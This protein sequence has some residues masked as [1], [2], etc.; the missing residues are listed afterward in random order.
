MKSYQ[1]PGRRRRGRG[2]S[3]S[4]RKQRGA[5]K[6]NNVVG[7]GL[8]GGAY[9][10]LSHQDMDRIH[11]TALDILENIGL[12]DP[13]ADLLALALEKGCWLNE[14]GRL[15]F[16]RALVEDVV[17]GACKEFTIYGRDPAFDIQL[18][19]SK[20]SYSVAG[21]AVTMFDAETKTYRPSTLL[22]LYDLARLVDRLDN[23]H[24]FC[25]PVIATDIT[26][27]YT[28]STNIAYAIL[29]ATR[30]SFSCAIAQ[31]EAI[32]N[33]VEMFDMVLGGEGEFRKR[34]FCT[35]GCCPIVSPL[36]FG[37]E[38][39]RV[40][41]TSVQLGIPGDFAVAPQA[42]A[43][44]PAAL[45]GTL[46]QVTAETLATIL[47]TNLFSP[48]HPTVYAAWPL[49]SDLRTGAFSGGSGEEALLSAAATQIG[50]FYGLPTSVGAGMTDSKIPDNQAGF[51][52]AL[53]TALAGHAGAN[54][55]GE[56]A[57]MLSSLL[58]C[59]L[60]A[61]VIDNDML[62]AVQRTIRG[63]EVT[64]ETLSYEIIERAVLGEGHFLG[65]DQTLAL[66][67]TEYLYPEISD[68]TPP[69]VWEEN[70]SLDILE[71][72][73]ERV[74][75]IL[76]TSYPSYIDPE[77]DDVIRASFQI[78]LPKDSMRPG[79]GRW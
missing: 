73:Q 78:V 55:I 38:G 9:Q 33:V 21:Q 58:G 45:A 31:P 51:E 74:R 68:R 3:R 76:S 37:E 10:P 17:D 6:T 5:G 65:S 62:G 77:M 75:E 54:Y 36:R 22:D 48:G 70:G 35:I 1:S 72:A 4:R 13:P 27:P 79:N 40:A 44:A 67:E 53:T 66:M 8:T 26:D 18:G 20:V 24:R 64:D 47:L 15:C 43:T 2:G 28:H 59:S 56:S 52:K 16:P 46:V 60:E 42:G 34:P 50:N 19:G 12:A 69:S 49:V 7:P 41:I 63:I 71:R 32:K 57:G 30:K 61:M 29:A 39:S 11:R 23:I 14:H 25:Q